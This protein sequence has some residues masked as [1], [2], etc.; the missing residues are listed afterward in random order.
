MALATL[1]FATG[2]G[3]KA[4]HLFLDRFVL[5]RFT[6]W[7]RRNRIELERFQAKWTPVRRSES[8]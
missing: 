1:L 3:V 6:A 8:A 4:A 7:R 5:K 2:L